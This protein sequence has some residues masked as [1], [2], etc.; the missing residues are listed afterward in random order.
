M[1]TK[2]LFAIILDIVVPEFSFVEPFG[3]EQTGLP[4][5]LWDLRRANYYQGYLDNI[6]TS[7]AAR[8]EHCKF[9]LSTLRAFN[10]DSSEGVHK[11]R[12]FGWAIYDDFESFSGSSVKF[13]MQ[14]LDLTLLEW[15][16]KA[17]MFQF[18]G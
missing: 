5:I 17:S 10:A 14:Y 3:R 8:V 16:P 9:P 4:A 1:I 13:G 2:E 6:L 18:L 12:A 7:L 15:R 11:T